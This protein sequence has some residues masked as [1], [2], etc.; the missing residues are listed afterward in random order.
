M[1]LT[2]NSGRK[3]FSSCYGI[4]PKINHMLGHRSSLNHFEKIEVSDVPFMH[5]LFNNNNSASIHR[6]MCLHGSFGIQVGDGETWVQ[7]KR[8]E[9][10]YKQAGLSPGSWFQ[11]VMLVTNP[12]TVLCSWETVYSHTWLW[13]PWQTRDLWRIMA[14]S[15]SGSKHTDLSPKG[16]PRVAHKQVTKFRNSS[17]QSRILCRYAY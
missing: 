6:Q 10:H 1:T 7:S 8:E 4:S 2:Q 16:E 15:A 13:V 12:E 9:N 11:T 14:T 5:P 3:L 17:M